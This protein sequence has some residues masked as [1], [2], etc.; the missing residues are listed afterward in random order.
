M[1]LRAA[2]SRLLEA[3]PESVHSSFAGNPIA[4]FIR[5]DL[6]ESVKEIVGPNQRYLVQGSAGQGVWAQVPWLAVFDRFVTKSAQDGYYVVYLVRQDCRGLYLSLNQGVTQLRGQYGSGTKETLRARAVNFQA[7]LGGF[8]TGN[9]ELGRIDLAASTGTSLAAYYEYGSICSIYYPATDLPSDFQLSIDLKRFLELYCQLAS[10]ES[11]LFEQTDA[12]DDELGLGDEDL[13]TLRQHKRVERNK[14]LA[15]RAK[16]IHGYQ[17]EACG[18]DFEE[19]YGAIGR[20]FIEAHHLTPLSAFQG[21]KLSLSPRDDFAVLCSNCHS[22]IHRSEFVGD[23]GG[24][25]ARYMGRLQARR[26]RRS[27]GG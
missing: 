21:Q 4:E 23:V 25:R 9:L 20:H 14:A 11:R 7:R 27:G 6:V 24:F 5:K 26:D 10:R 12:E 17:C 15:A 19:T 1:S 16:K 18:L 8:Q 13:R 3:Y 2:F 22:M